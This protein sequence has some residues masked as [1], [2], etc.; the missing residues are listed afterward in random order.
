MKKDKDLKKLL[1]EN[2]QEYDPEPTIEK[3]GKQL[4]VDFTKYETKHNKKLTNSFILRPIISAAI[5]VAVI[6]PVGMV[7]GYYIMKSSI[8]QDDGVVGMK[9][10]DSHQTLAHKINLDTEL[11]IYFLYSEKSQSFFYG[12][13][14][15]N[16]SKETN[17]E[18][19][20]TI[21]LDGNTEIVLDDLNMLYTSEISIDKNFYYTVK[22]N[23]ISE[24]LYYNTSAYYLEM[25]SKINAL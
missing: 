14:C 21:T 12:A 19:K 18:H 7:S 16:T 10:Y 23:D 22:Y 8:D 24:T 9:L 11:R 5:A 1:K 15:R 4:G 2:C 17:Y 20:V 25:E 3:A 13:T 6:L